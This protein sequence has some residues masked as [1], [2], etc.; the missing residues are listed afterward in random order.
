M[1]HP[2]TVA[3]FDRALAANRAVEAL[4][5]AG[6]AKER[7]SIVCPTCSDTTFEGIENVDSSGENTPERAVAGGAIGAL[8]G[9]ATAAVGMAATGGAG[10][11]VVGPFLG[12]AAA[13]GVA[14]GFLGAMSTRGIEPEIADYFDQALQRGQVLVAVE[15]DGKPPLTEAHRILEEH[16]AET[17][18]LPSAG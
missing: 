14:G 18:R 5:D 7:L 4:V 10:L 16:G 11:L 15:P 2:V 12:A 9:G 13:G 3:V 6:F 17:K 1:T 8:L